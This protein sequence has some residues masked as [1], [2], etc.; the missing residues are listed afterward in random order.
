MSDNCEELSLSTKIHRIENCMINL[1][2]YLEFTIAQKINLLCY[3]EVFTV[4]D[5]NIFTLN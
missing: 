1:K 5:W 3:V 2:R 4:A